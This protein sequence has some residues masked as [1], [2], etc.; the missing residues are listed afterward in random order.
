MF[1]RFTMSTKEPKEFEVKYPPHLYTNFTP[2]AAAWTVNTV[3]FYIVRMLQQKSRPIRPNGVS[4]LIFF[5]PSWWAYANSSLSFLFLADK[6]FTWCAV[7]CCCAFSDALLD[8]L[9]VT[10][11]FLWSWSV[12]TMFIRTNALYKNYKSMYVCI[13]QKST[14][15]NSFIVKGTDTTS[16]SKYL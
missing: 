7:Y 10:S 13:I 8:T 1:K 15:H 3:N 6:S 12:F 2:P 11:A 16:A 9:D 14:W 4:V 5:V